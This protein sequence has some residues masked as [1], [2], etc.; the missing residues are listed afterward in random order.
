MSDTTENCPVSWPVVR[1]LTEESISTPPLALYTKPS[2]MI[3]GPAIVVE[4]VD[5]R[6]SPF[7]QTGKRIRVRP[8]AG[9]DVHSVT[10]LFCAR[11][12]PK[13][14]S[15]PVA[16]YATMSAELSPWRSPM[17]GVVAPFI[18]VAMTYR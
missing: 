8:G 15:P 7:A 14:T 18:G 4:I 5:R 3:S 16:E 1:R 11:S 6:A 2:A 10:N 13:A 9:F 12:K 17:A